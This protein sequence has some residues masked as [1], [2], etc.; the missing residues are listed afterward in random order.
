[1][2]KINEDLDP[3]IS[4]STLEQIDAT[5]LSQDI[6]QTMDLNKTMDIGFGKPIEK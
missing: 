2:Y 3:V 1:M 6:S 4:N 5:L